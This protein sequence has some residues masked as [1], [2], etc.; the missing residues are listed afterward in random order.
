MFVGAE[1]LARLG[2]KISTSLIERLNQTFRHALAPLVRKSRSF[3]KEREPLKR[4]VVFF[5]AFYNFARPLMSLRV[6]LP[7]P[8]RIS[9]GLFQPKWKQ[10]TPRAWRLD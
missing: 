10:R 5:Q 2:L 9:Q 6:A 7:E 4:R 8:Q 1:K 3:C